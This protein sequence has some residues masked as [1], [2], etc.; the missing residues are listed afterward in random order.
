M[1]KSVYKPTRAELKLC[2]RLQ[3]RVIAHYKRQMAGK[4][5]N[6]NLGP[7]LPFVKKYPKLFMWIVNGASDHWINYNRRKYGLKKR[8]AK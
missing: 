1:K 8:G 7:A 5:P 4:V 3:K 2:R 6:G